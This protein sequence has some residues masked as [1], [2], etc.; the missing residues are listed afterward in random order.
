MLTIIVFGL[1]IG[2]LIFVH[3]LGHFLVAR[4]NG[5]KADEFGFGFPPRALGIY[6]NENTHKWELVWGKR[7]VTSSNTVYSLNWLPLGGFVK[8][9]GEDGHHAGEPDS[10]GSKSAW[11]RVKVLLAGVTMNF[12]LAWF[13]LTVAL[14]IG[15]P[16]AVDRDKGDYK[17]IKIQISQV[18]EGTPAQAMGVRIGDEVMR[19]VGGD[20]VCQANFAGSAAV[21]QYIA[22]HKGTEI[23]LE[24]KRGKD[25]VKLT[26]TPRTDA[27][28][29]QGSLGIGLVETAIISYPWYRAIVEG[30]FY[31]LSM[32]WSILVTL[33][34][35]I[36]GLF[37]GQKAAVDVAGPVGIVY[38]TKQVTDLGFVYILQFIAL[39]SV[40]LGIINGFPF[41]ALDGGRVLFILIESLKGS[42]VSQKFEN[43]VHTIGFALLILLM[44]FVTFK[45]IIRFDI[46][47]KIG[48]LF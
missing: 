19:C 45:D 12:L 21:V 41:P 8:I 27:P 6:F 47:A 3:E 13:V 18:L 14:I 1:I 23:V 35:V 40:N 42:P 15:T 4:R 30:L 5:I 32:I 20:P 17:D 9:K 39:L 29:D 37:L 10:F 7:H 43:T 22:A 11:T 25:L 36:Q 44:L 34:T 24:V 28:V 26:G 2:L 31:T 33:V 38:F 46:V 48:N 16:Q